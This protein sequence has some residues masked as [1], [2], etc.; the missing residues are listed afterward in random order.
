MIDS[1]CQVTTGSNKSKTLIE[2]IQQRRTSLS[3]SRF[4][5]GPFHA[6]KFPVPDEKAMQNTSF[7]TASWLRN[8]LI[9][10]TLTASRRS[11][12]TG[13]VV[14]SINFSMDKASFL[15]MLK[16]LEIL[17]ADSQTLETPAK[18]C[19]DKSKVE[20]VAGKTKLE[21]IQLLIRLAR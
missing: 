8:P 13:L 6:C 20:Q 10:R 11:C 9:P 7:A 14:F 21:A 15:P 17:D 16:A 5:N 4:V 1:T 12:T 19:G 2:L 3:S 18:K